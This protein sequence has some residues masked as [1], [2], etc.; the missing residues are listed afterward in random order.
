[1]ARRQWAAGWT[2][3]EREGEWHLL[4][5]FCDIVLHCVTFYC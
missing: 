2:R 5:S 4:L 1:M 3:R